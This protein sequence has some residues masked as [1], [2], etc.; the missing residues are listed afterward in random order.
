M[1]PPEDS[2]PNT[3]SPEYSK[4]ADRQENNLS[5]NF[6]EMIEEGQLKMNKSLKELEENPAKKVARNQ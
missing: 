4:T 6:M 2:Y 1:S 3:A 5:T